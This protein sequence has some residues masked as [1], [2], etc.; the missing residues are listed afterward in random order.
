MTARIKKSDFV[1]SLEKGLKVIAAFD[2]H[3]PRQTLTQAAKAVKLTRANARRI[4]LTL[5]HLGYVSA[6][7]GRL[8]NLTPKVLCLGYA[9]LSGLTFREIAQPFMEALADKVNESCSM[10]VLD[11]KEIVYVARVHTKRIM[12]ISLG[13]GSRLPIHA[14][15]MGAMLMAGMDT[16]DM[17]KA[18]AGY[19]FVSFT[20]HT[21]TGRKKFI[22]HINKVR[23]LGWALSDQ[24]LEI[25]V[26]SVACAL[27]DKHGRTLAALNISGHASRVSTKEMVENFLP[28]L[29]DT[30][31]KIEGALDKF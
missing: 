29:K 25:G 7:D 13:I 18:V 26:R 30:V 1:Q 24:E 3:H 14:T 12:T 10:S 23:E 31:S 11:G 19:K 15:S 4:L 27:K 8:F 9:Y 17:Q 20:P 6:Q 16:A 28:A 2:S 21:I 22:Q 5:E